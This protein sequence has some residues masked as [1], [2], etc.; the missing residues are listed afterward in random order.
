MMRFFGY[1]LGYVFGRTEGLFIALKKQPT[2]EELDKIV[3]SITKRIFEI[4]SRIHKT[5]T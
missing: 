1:I 3:K 4:K 2:A 5:N